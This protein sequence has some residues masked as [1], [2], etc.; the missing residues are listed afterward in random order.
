MLESSVLPFPWTPEEAL[1]SLMDM[2]QR[3]ALE[4]GGEAGDGQEENGESEEDSAFQADEPVADEPVAPAE[5]EAPEDEAP[6]SALV[7]KKP[8]RAVPTA[9]PAAGPKKGKGK[10]P[11]G[12]KG[13]PIKANKGK[14]KNG[15]KGQA[16]KGHKDKEG[17]ESEEDGEA[18]KLLVLLI[19]WSTC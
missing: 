14:A 9:L 5:V 19:S 7:K 8:A 1:E 15:G 18:G 3:L 2:Q 13:K 16:N 4:G 17:G 12:G 11:Q 10:A 6:V